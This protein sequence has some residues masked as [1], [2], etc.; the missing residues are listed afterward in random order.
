MATIR[1]KTATKATVQSTKPV[2]ELQD[3]TDVDF[4]TL[5]AA[6]DGKVV[7]YDNTTGKFVLIDADTILGRSSEDGNLSDEFI[8]QI[9][10]QIDLGDTQGDIDGGVFS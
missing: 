6:A 4:G 2:R 1:R 9:E 7:S 8:T 5:N 10:T 3:A